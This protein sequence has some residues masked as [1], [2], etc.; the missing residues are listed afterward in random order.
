MVE[1]KIMDI[2]D[3]KI[4]HFDYD[5]LK[6]FKAECEL[7]VT[8]TLHEYRQL[9]QAEAKAEARESNSARWKAEAK[10]DE[11]KKEI[12]SLKAEIESLRATEDK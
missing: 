12:A 11:L 5:E 10:I 2:K 8:I 4:E 6:N 7:T 1:Y 9:L 3:K